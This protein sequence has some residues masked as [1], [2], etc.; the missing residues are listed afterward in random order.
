MG[1]REQFSNFAQTLM[2]I[3]GAAVFVL[4]ASKEEGLPLRVAIGV[5]GLGLL[6]FLGTLIWRG[7]IDSPHRQK[8][9]ALVSRARELADGVA[10]DVWT[11]D[12][13]EQAFR[14]HLPRK[15]TMQVER[16]EYA[17]SAESAAWEGLR[18]AVR[19]SAKDTFPSSQ[20]EP[21]QTGGIITNTLAALEDKRDRVRSDDLQI[22]RQRLTANPAIGPLPDIVW[23][24]SPIWATASS[25]PA[26][27]ITDPELDERIQK[28]REWFDETSKGEPAIVYRDALWNTHTDRRELAKA[29]APILEYGR[30]DWSRRCFFCR[31]K[32]WWQI[33]R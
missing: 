18:D 14:A 30:L 2:V 17:T 15:A 19:Q 9:V 32:R 33:W 21:W 29:I 12:A 7:G 11:N 24:N 13:E 4:I 10:L 20:A 8:V 6:L 16:V 5:F 28:V 25:W 1:R 27:T 23:G 22:R 31:P 26:A 3:G